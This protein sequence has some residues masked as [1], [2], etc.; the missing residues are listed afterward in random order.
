MK[1]YQR[2]SLGVLIGVVSFAT[3][4]FGV[5]WSLPDIVDLNKYKTDF[6][7]AI[8]EQSGFKFSCEDI[9]LSRSLSPYL[10]VQMHHT[11]ILYPN[12]EV[13]LKLKDSELKVKLL[14]LLFKK[15]VV[16]DAKLTR[17]IINLTLY[18]DFSTSLERYFDTTKSI[19]TN[20]FSINAVVKDTICER[21]K[22]KIQDETTGKLFYLEGDELLLKDVKL[23]E[24]AH[25]ILKGSLFE[26]E[27]EYLKYDLDV[28]APLIAQK[29]KFTFS[30]FKAIYDSAIT[31]EILG[32]LQF[33]KN[34]NI[35]GYL[36][37]SNLAM[38]ADDLILSDNNINLIFKGQEAQIKSILHSS[39]DDV[40]NVEGKLA[41]G[42]KKN[43]DLTTKAKNINLKNL[44][45]VLT[46]IAQ[47]LNVPNQLKDVSITGLLDADFIIKSDFQKLK[48][49]GTAKVINAQIKHN[50]LP[51]TISNIN[52][53]VN[54]DN[55]NILI[56]QAEALLNS[57]P[58]KIV[59]KVNEDVSYDINIFSENLKLK[60]IIQLFKIKLPVTVNKGDLSLTTQISG[61][62]NKSI[63][64]D[65]NIVLTDLLIIEPNSKLPLNIK[66]AQVNFKTDSKKYNGNVVL[67]D[68]SASYQKMPIRAKS[69]NISFDDKKII[70]PE[71]EL[72][73]VKSP[74]KYSGVI[75]DYLNKPNAIISFDGNLFS[76]NLAEIIK[77]FINQPHK[78][79]GQLKT[80]GKI[81][82]N[83]S[84]ADIKMEVKADSQN[85]LS[86]L[87]IKE[88]LNKPSKLTLDASLKDNNL[89]LK[90]VSLKENIE[91]VKAEIIGINGSVNFEKNVVLEDLKLIVPN[92]VSFSTNFFGGEDISLTADLLLDGIISNPIIKGRANI[93]SLNIK[94]YLTAIRNADVNFEQNKIKVTAPDVQIN[95]SKLNLY[96]EIEKKIKDK[97]ELSNVNLLC[98]NLDVN[99]LFE[100]I[101]KEA[102]PFAKSL[103]TVKNGIAIINNFSILDLKARDISADFSLNDNVLNVKN[104]SANAYNGE[105]SGGFDYDIPHSNLQ[106]NLNGKNIDMKSSLYDLCKLDD[107]I[108]GIADFQTDISMVTGE[109][110]SVL[111]SLNGNLNFKS[112][113]GKMGTLGKFEYYLYA[114]NIL[115][116]GL[117]KT[118]LNRIADIF[119]KG[120]DTAQY[121]TAEGTI[122]FDNGYMSTQNV[123]TIGND[124]SLSVKGRHNLVSNQVNIDIYG[125]ISDEITSQLGS[126]G[127]ISISD[128]LE[129]NSQKTTNNLLFVPNSVI[130]DI[131]LLYN[132]GEAKTNTFKVNLLGDI[133]SL[134]AINSFMWILP[135]ENK[136]QEPDVL[137]EFSDMLQ[138]L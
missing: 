118:T 134:S 5:L 38:K 58:I 49:S 101:E 87:V 25:F 108:A 77:E 116:H 68:V 43:I 24:K 30:P 61:K 135:Q 15:V 120:G 103:I 86:Y 115:Y 131:P 3:L 83:N 80:N 99:T 6:A 59:G 128:L 20:G 8:E 93:A 33:D 27:K 138:N 65:S 13:F 35:D 56:E 100:L 55:N 57:T 125:R 84:S 18:N 104:I 114:Q 19:N 97:L 32:K 23:N 46:I 136:P 4:Y 36:N 12:D 17:P 73:I 60:N 82:L 39:K 92:T 45:K 11:L 21:Y 107:N 26:N 52:A 130:E 106:I 67:S 69:L 124:M 117:L 94:K 66:N 75:N 37:A 2:I 137:P 10:N 98:A 62:L 132:Q 53:N 74:F 28:I 122:T 34:N 14:P 54:L 76:S 72:F 112:T 44:H 109:Y 78:A 105:V 110:N 129:N 85:Y 70:I 89:R 96:A 50:T 123:K 42:K 16:Q 127:N 91:D 133:N 111:N 63:N 29:S 119:K 102:N 48:S 121:R 40:V 47:T 31:G 79:L 126:F 9:K 41:Y 71:N 88:L 1:K 51:Y 113:N 7:T 81:T 95:N 22:L 90:S 64:A